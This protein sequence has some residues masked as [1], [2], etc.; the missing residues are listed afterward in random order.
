VEEHRKAFEIW[1][2][3]QAYDPY[4]YLDRFDDE[5]EQPGDY[6]FHL[7][8]VAWES[9]QAAIEHAKKTMCNRN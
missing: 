4:P 5:E 7:V 3:E 6:E 1:M 8:Q 9:W 2:N